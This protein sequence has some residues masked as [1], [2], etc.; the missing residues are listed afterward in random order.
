MSK[1]IKKIQNNIFSQ[2]FFE[3][4]DGI[5]VGVSGGPDSVALVRA[6]LELK[7]K[8]QLK[9]QLVHVNYHLR[10]K[11]SELD[12]ALVRKLAKQNNLDLLVD[13]FKSSKK[14]N[15][16]AIYREYRYRIFEKVRREKDFQWIAVGHTLDDQVETVIMNLLRG[17]GME[18]LGGMK[19]KNGKIIRPLLVFEKKEILAYLKAIEQK[20]RLDQTNL[21]TKLLRNRIRKKL[22]PVLEKEY[23]PQI[24]R[25]IDDLAENLRADFEIIEE[26]G[27]K[28][29]NK[30]VVVEGRKVC[31]LDLASYQN[32]G[33]AIRRFIFRKI[34]ATI[35][36]RMNLSAALYHEFEKMVSSRKGKNQKLKF[37]QL[38]IERKGQK[39]FFM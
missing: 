26:I 16:E 10:G 35:S 28:A 7:K 2:Q 37:Q 20:F 36:S 12:E 27:N 23:N 17:A 18:G 33:S 1:F 31:H 11:D 29:Y 5:V 8:Y 34:I 15:P 22:I 13:D 3:V 25:R 32:Y 14:G 30:T 4:G 19:P 38:V 39:V 6:L 24:K 21:D 9:L